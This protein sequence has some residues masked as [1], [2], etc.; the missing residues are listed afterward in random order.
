MKEITLRE[1]LK[2][3]PCSNGLKKL[4]NGLSYSSPV[5]ENEKDLPIKTLFILENNGYDDCLWAL[6]C[7][8]RSANWYRFKADVAESVLK[9]Y[10]NMYPADNRPRLAIEAS[11]NLADNIDYSV[12]YSVADSA[13]S[14][15]YSVADSADSASDS[16]RSVAYSA[17]YSADSA[18]DSARSVAYSASYSARSASDSADS[19]DSAAEKQRQLN[20]EILKKY[21]L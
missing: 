20:I 1:I 6:R 21:I 16:A 9:Y 11:R 13:R 2:N 14:V 8:S 17:S 15:A 12:A 7:F 18:S 5:T 10:E 19:A 4:L 3:N